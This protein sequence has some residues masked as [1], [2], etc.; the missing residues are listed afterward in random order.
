MSMSI[1]TLRTSLVLE[2]LERVKLYRL[3]ISIYIST[4]YLCRLHKPHLHACYRDQRY[5]GM[6]N[7]TERQGRR[8][9]RRKKGIECI[10]ETFGDMNNPPPLPPPGNYLLG[11]ALVVRRL[12][13]GRTVHYIG[14]PTQSGHGMTSWVPFLLE[15]AIW[16][17]C[18]HDSP[19]CMHKSAIIRFKITYCYYQVT[20]APCSSWEYC[21]KNP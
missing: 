14:I 10:R 8:V 9:V 18:S 2:K 13:E 11:V 12:V 1:L 17:I 21:T 5:P 6:P 3:Y 7:S 16:C 20:W 19:T 15:L 4:R